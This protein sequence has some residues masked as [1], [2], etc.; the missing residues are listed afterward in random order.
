MLALAVGPV[1]Y[2]AYCCCSYATG[3]SL[4]IWW[5]FFAVPRL[6]LLRWELRSKH[7]NRWAWKAVLPLW[8]VQW[9]IR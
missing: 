2:F 7:L 5:A 9:L 3:V 8:G 1:G 6:I 4:P